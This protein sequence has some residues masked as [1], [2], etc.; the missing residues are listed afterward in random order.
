MIRALSSAVAPQ[1]FAAA[2]SASLENAVTANL[3]AA[4]QHA[5]K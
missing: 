4:E 5:K 2:F 3:D 1:L